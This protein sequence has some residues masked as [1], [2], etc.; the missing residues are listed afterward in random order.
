MVCAYLL[1]ASACV[2]ADP[3]A[4]FVRRMDAAP[5]GERLPDWERTRRL[6]LRE[7]LAVGQVAPDFTLATADGNTTITRSAFHESRPLVLIFGSYT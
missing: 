3:A 5:P 4:D 6:I 1:L 2:P 7:A